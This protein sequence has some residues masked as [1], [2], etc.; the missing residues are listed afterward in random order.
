MQPVHWV[1]FPFV[2]HREGEPF[3]ERQ[4]QSLRG[5]RD[6]PP[7]LLQDVELIGMWLGD[8][9]ISVCAGS[10]ES[11][12]PSVV[13]MYR[14][15]F[16][17]ITTPSRMDFLSTVIPVVSLDITIVVVCIFHRGRG[18]VR[19]DA[20]DPARKVGG[21]GQLPELRAVKVVWVQVFL[22]SHECGDVP[23]SNYAGV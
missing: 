14:R 20:D 17:G 16:K 3:R 9:T 2:F 10:L 5:V 21:C 4:C 23:R 8:T 22:W 12:S 18:G 19:C 11:S 15:S 13:S 7:A 6:C 1:E